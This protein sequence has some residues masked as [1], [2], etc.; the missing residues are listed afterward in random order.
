MATVAPLNEE[1]VTLSPRKRTLE[2]KF[3]LRHESESGF[4]MNGSKDKTSLDKD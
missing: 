2:N 4:A 1:V 3:L